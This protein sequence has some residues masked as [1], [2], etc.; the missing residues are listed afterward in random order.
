MRIDGSTNV[1]E[2]KTLFPASDFELATYEA[3][4]ADQPEDTD[5][6][7]H[8]LFLTL[9][10]L[11]GTYMAQETKF[12]EVM[13]C[14]KA[15]FRQAKRRKANA[16]TPELRASFAAKMKLLKHI[17]QALV[18]LH[19]DEVNKIKAIV[20][21][22]AESMQELVSSSPGKQAFGRPLFPRI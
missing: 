9:R 20:D 10:K 5:A 4:D 19:E 6:P 3:I 8:K 16:K 15:V 14:N 1:Y 21:G 18:A 7:P 12:A 13:A 22:L 11:H 2:L 17:K